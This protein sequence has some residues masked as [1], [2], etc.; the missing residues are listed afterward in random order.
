MIATTID[1]TDPAFDYFLT[2]AAMYEF[3]T[4]QIASNVM[5]MLG[6]F[7]GNYIHRLIQKYN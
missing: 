5:H 6:I 1:I 7:S 3:R 4:Q 2:Q